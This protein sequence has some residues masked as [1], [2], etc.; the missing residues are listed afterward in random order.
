MSRMMDF[1]PGAPGIDG[2]W[3]SSAKNGLGTA[4]SKT[5]PVWF[6]LSHGIL[7]EIYYPRVDSACTRDFG[8]V[9]TGPNGYFSEEKRDCVSN[10][11]PFD[12]GIPAFTIVNTARDETYRIEKQ[13]ITDPARASVLQQVSFTPL[14]GTMED[15]R[16]T[17]LLAPHLVNAGKLNSAWIGE[18][19]GRQILFA[20]GR[21]RYLALVS[22]APWQAASAGFVGFS[23]G[24]Q[25]LHES[26]CLSEQYSRADDGNVALAG[27][28]SRFDGGSRHPPRGRP[29]GAVVAS[30]SIPW[31]FSKGDGDLG[32]YHLVW[33][34]DLVE[35]AGGFLAIGR[36]RTRR[37]TSSTTCARPRPPRAAGH[38]T[39]GSTDGP[40]GTACRWTRSPSRSCS[41][42][43]SARGPPR[44]RRGS[45]PSC[46][47][48]TRAAGYMLMNGPA[49][50]RTAGRRTPATA[51]SPSPSRSPRCW[52]RRPIDWSGRRCKCARICA[53]PPIA[54][55]SRSRNGPSR[56]TRTCASPPSRAIT[57]ASPPGATDTAGPTGDTL[58]KNQPPDRAILPSEHVLSARTR[59]RLCASACAHR[60]SAHLDTIA[61]IDH[62]LKRRAAAGSPVV[63]L[64]RRRLRRT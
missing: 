3:T 17:A 2:R 7:N 34:R 9:V 20:S 53:K 59:W 50:A 6:T 60:R 33:P 25:Q 55:T 32:G 8:F 64:H 5:S 37:S 26:G 21:S 19:E 62:A 63:P 51:P 61:A 44:R 28:L 31:G 46:R 52:P 10:T 24:W 45:K 11:Q 12:G 39:C 4:L 13:V 58:I 29:P 22:D 15:Y 40:I 49:T 14:K 35:T 47:M 42:T 38:R 27:G 41:P 54:G 18:F 57:C 56:A 1:A 23:D 43:C 48:V 36:R 16:V 30:L